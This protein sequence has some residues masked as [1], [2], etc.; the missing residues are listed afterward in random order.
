MSEESRR[1]VQTRYAASEKGKAA[2]AK[3]AASEKGKKYQDKAGASESHRAALAKYETTEKAKA[4]RARYFAT[5]GK[6]GAVQAMYRI[7]EEGRAT[8]AKY[9]A[10]EKGRL[11]RVARTARRRCQ[12]PDEYIKWFDRL[13]LKRHKPCAKCGRPWKQ[14]HQ[15]DHIVALALGGK[16]EESNYQVL[17]VDCH[18]A[19][20]REDLREIWK[21][22][23]VERLGL[24]VRPPVACQF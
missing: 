16:D 21:A 12:A 22:R 15:L 20:T 17:C 6:G 9:A 11:S 2:H 7:S 1:A 18:R 5:S 4:R 3:Y 19:K 14:S 13:L 24:S 8:Q 23:R 10:S